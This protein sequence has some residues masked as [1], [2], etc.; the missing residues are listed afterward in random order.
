[1]KATRAT[2]CAGR[3]TSFLSENRI[4]NFII[5]NRLLAGLVPGLALL[6]FADQFVSEVRLAMAQRE[7]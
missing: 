1:M 3:T 6:L 7:L 4:K 2:V 5:E